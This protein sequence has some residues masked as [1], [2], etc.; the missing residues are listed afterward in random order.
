MTDPRRPLTW[1]DYAR[2]QFRL[3]WKVFWRNRRSTFIGFLLPV[4]LDLAVATPLRGKELGGVNAAAYTTLGFVGFA[5]VTAFINLLNGIV[6]RR[7]DLVLKRLRGTEVPPSAVLAGQFGAAGAV[8]LLQVLLLGA[9]AVLWFDA[10]LPTDPLLAL[11]V[12]GAGFLLFALLAAAL[13]GLT[14]GA[15][16]TPMV[17]TP[18]LLLS[19][20]AGGVATP[21][22]SLPDWLQAPAHALPLTPVVEALRTAWFG[23]AFG[24]ESWSGPPL[25]GLGLLDT[26]AHAAPS[27]LLLAA[28]TAAAAALT[29]R[30]FRWEPRHA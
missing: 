6:A 16:A 15:E 18:V 11:V 8:L 22:G 5:L 4:L 1:P 12:L 27:L 13:S 19:M 14:P 17:A 9:L 25:P 28:W 24:A 7:D 10:P 3:S 30:L 29:R 21:V 23:R 2:A 20:F 26:W